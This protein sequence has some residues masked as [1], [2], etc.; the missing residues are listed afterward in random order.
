ME[1]KLEQE[2]GELE[3]ETILQFTHSQ[4]SK[5]CGIQIEA[6]TVLL[7]TGILDSLGLVELIMSV[8]DQFQITVDLGDLKKE[9]FDTPELMTEFF[10][11]N[12]S[13][14]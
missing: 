3:K 7:T 4:L 10:Y 9:I 12:K 2:N 13:R 14:Q 1:P 11:Q 6:S 5:I 8:Q